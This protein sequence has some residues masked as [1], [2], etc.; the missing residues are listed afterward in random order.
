[1]AKYQGKYRNESI[2]ADWWDYSHNATYFITICTKDREHFFGAIRD[3]IMGLSAIGCI[4]YTCWEE[5]PQHFPFVRLGEFIAM[6]DH[7]HG[8]IIIDKQEHVVTQDFVSPHTREDFIPPHAGGD[9]QKNKFGPQSKN[10]A[11]IVRG[12]KVGITKQA[13]VITPDF[14]WQS[15]YHDH[16]IRNRHSFERISQ[17]I[18]NNPKNWQQ[19]RFTGQSPS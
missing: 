8:I 12:F 11:S 1:M 13:R 17:Y 14:A 5:I 19:D 2:R 18:R 3:G 16:I 7:V 4:A 6:P 10:L 15:R 9:F